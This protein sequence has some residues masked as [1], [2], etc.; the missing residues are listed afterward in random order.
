MKSVS[1]P[2]R[3]IAVALWVWGGTVAAF[4]QTTSAPYPPLGFVFVQDII[5]DITLD[6]RYAGSHNFAGT[7]I[8]GYDAPLAILRAEA[9]A[10]LK[11]VNASLRKKE[12]GLKIFDAYRPEQAVQHFVRWAENLSDTRMK[13]QFYP[14]VDKSML[15]Q[16]GYIARR[17]GH[18]RGNTV[19][20]TL[21]S[22]KTGQELDMGSP[23]DFFGKISHHGAEGI[24]PAQA[25]NRATLREAM[26][27]HGF[28]RIKEE[29]WHYTLKEEPAPAFA[30]FPIQNPA[31]ASPAVQ[32]TLE[33]AAQGA[34][35]VILVTDGLGTDSKNNRAVLSAWSKNEGIWTHR[36]S[37]AGWLG[38]T[39]F[40]QNKR[41]GDGATPTG[42]FTFGR[43]F[44]NAENPGTP[45]PY[46]KVSKN[47][48]WVDDPQSKFYNQWAHSDAPD[49][50][51][52][53][54]ERLSDYAKQYE[55]AVSVNYNTAPIL[56]GKGSAIFLHVATGRPT[57]GC[58]AVPRAAMIF[59][60][61]FIEKDTKIVLGE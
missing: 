28:K 60:L 11:A 19:D 35:R 56:P 4:A 50:D 25:A 24:T 42:I 3:A 44:G 7:Q 17:S 6:I 31:P 40:R 54:A 22:L 41:E 20:L 39:G 15:F 13:S 12:L 2:V 38:K 49:A 32:S 9:A 37:T 26:E 43:A 58:I 18:S 29:W 33:K 57:A 48:V 36:F 23:F 5:P 8:D 53:S 61:G 27:A 1:A 59:F 51:W 47:D 52:S 55:Y 16:E 10:A 45:L 46:T 30:N 14:E 21:I 34:A